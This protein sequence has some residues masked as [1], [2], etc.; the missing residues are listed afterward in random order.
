MMKKLILV[1][2]AVCLLATASIVRA[3]TVG[4]VPVGGA[5]GSDW[6]QEFNESGVGNFNWL[7]VEMVTGSLVNPAFTGF[8]S[9]GWLYAAGDEVTDVA[10]SGPASTNLDWY[11][12]FAGPSS[13]PLTFY[14]QAY[15]G[16]NLVDSAIAGWTGSG[17]QI[18]DPGGPQSRQITSPVL[19][20]PISMIFFGTGLVAVSGYVSRRRMLRKA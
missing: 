16:S 7:Q 20:E 11:I 10:Y 3:G 13:T 18:A 14:F 6:S 17:W 4:L 9:P 1:W 2:A 5:V 19:P 8:S 12:N 15:D